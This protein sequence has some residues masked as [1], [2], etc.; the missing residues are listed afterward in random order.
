MNKTRIV[1]TLICLVGFAAARTSAAESPLESFFRHYLDE[2]FALHPVE[3]TQLGDHRFDDKLDD[4]SPAALEHS[5]EHLKKTHAR[6]HK[7][8]DHSKLSR[9]AQ[10]DFDIFDH[11][12]ETSIWLRE[13]T[14]PFADNPRAYNE[15]ISDSVF[16]LL[17]QSR[18]P[19]ET[20]VANAMARMKQIPRIIEAAKQNL[21]NPPHVVTET[22]A[23]Q[24]KGSIGFYESDIF[25]F[26][27]ESPQLPALKAECAQVVSAL[28]EYQQWL[29]K[30]LLPRA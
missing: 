10:I 25:Q 13:N 2:S 27:G 4:L 5:L 7:E 19:K 26:V 23:R 16:L 24:N 3:A 20:N 6:L 9:E 8:I 14:K 15:Y 17:T 28:K 18:L 30:D 29:E 22:A 11:D 21:K 12:L 1:L